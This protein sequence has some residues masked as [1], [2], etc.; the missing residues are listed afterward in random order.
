MTKNI[1]YQHVYVIQMIQYPNIL[2]SLIYFGK[3]RK[4]FNLRIIFKYF[5]IHGTH[6]K[7]YF[8]SLTRRA[9]L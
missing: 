3:T 7:I 4:S 8:E 9:M 2:E 6:F 5:L 1:N